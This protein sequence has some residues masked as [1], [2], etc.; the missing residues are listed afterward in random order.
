M[1][2]QSVPSV[3]GSPVSGAGSYQYPA[4]MPGTPSGTTAGLPTGGFSASGV[5]TAGSMSVPGGSSPFTSSSVSPWGGSID[6]TSFANIQNLTAQTIPYAESSALPYY[7]SGIGALQK[8]YKQA[9]N[10]QQ[11][12]YNEATP[13]ANQYAAAMGLLGQGPQQQAIAAFM[14][15]PQLQAQM[16]LG[17]AAVNAQMA[18]Q[19]FTNTGN[20]EIAL[21]NYN[22]LLGQQ[23]WGQYL[24]G[25]QPFMQE[26]QTAGQQIS[27]LQAA[28]GQGVNTGLSQ[29]GGMMYGA[30]MTGLGYLTSDQMAAYNAAAQQAAT[31]AAMVTGLGGAAISGLGTLLGGTGGLL[32][33]SDVNA[34]ENIEPV[35]K[36]ADGMNIY[37]YSYKDDPASTPHI[38]LLAQEVEQVAP[39]AVG[40]FPG[41][42]K[43]VNYALATNR[44]ASLMKFANDNASYDGS[45]MTR[46]YSSG[47]MERAA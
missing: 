16:Q 9:E 26:Q 14:S 33:L 29:I 18:K 2:F 15:S 11:Q 40:E 12:L 47:L 41:G 38:G 39:E 20:N 6:P 1:S 28:L 36:L 24:Q 5:P 7:T 22:Q 27:G 31:Q 43:G 13:G 23:G 37:R 45:P 35:G 10:T 17:D 44:A 25:L 32:K 19:G 30:P 21:S 4:T 8:Y 34:K 46:V 42:M 3:W